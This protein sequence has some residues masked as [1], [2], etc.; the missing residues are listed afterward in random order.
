ML[1]IIVCPHCWHEFAPADIL[2]IAAH[3]DLR[4]DLVLGGE[5]H[6]RF[7]P[8]RF[9]LHCEAIDAKGF[10]CQRLAC[11]RCHLEISRDFLAAP[12]FFLS[13]IGVPACG[14]SYFLTA[15]T[16]QARRQAP[17]VLGLAFQDADADANRII[18]SYEETL[19]LQDDPAAL[20]TIEKTEEQGYLYDQIML[21]GQ[22]MLLPKPFLFSLNPLKAFSAAHGEKPPVLCL[23]DNAGESFAPGKD[24]T[25]SP[26]TRHILRSRALLFLF[27]PA[28]DPR[29]RAACRGVSDDPQIVG[30]GPAIVNQTPF[31]AETAQ[32]F[33]RAAGLD[34]HE[35]IDRLLVVV[36]TK[37]D[38][39]G[40]LLPGIDLQSEPVLGPADGDEELAPPPPMKSP[41][42]TQGLNGEKDEDG[43]AFPNDDE[44]P[45]ANVAQRTPPKE[46][47]KFPGGVKRLNMERIAKTSSALRELFVK[48][49]PEIVSTAESCFTR[50][51]FIPVSALGTGPRLDPETQGLFV[52]AGELCPRWAA[53]PLF[54]ALE[55]G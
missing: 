28:K 38:I 45:N 30:S 16:W 12:A 26:V 35:P 39:W 46:Q 43:L 15:Q 52:R 18:N 50:V 20:V 3:G 21:D 9:N 11:P 37:S 54:Y 6:Q 1:K 24:T 13:I 32:R 41:E 2:W 8:S 51:A 27:D 17:E 44:A 34:N 48:F 53:V 29:F 4:G 36:V 55:N 19:F 23:Y 31:L 5:H 40:K 42:I 33:R 14:K 25:A 47:S 7:L 22:R 49:C 10:A